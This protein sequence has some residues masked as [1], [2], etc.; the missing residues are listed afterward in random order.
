MD[1]PAEYVI[2]KFGGQSALARLIG[3][4]QSTVQHWAST[5]HIPAK[6]HRQILELAA[7]HGIDVR[8]EDLVVGSPAP[9]PSPVAQSLLPVAVWQG[10]LQ[11][12]NRSVPCCVLDDGRRIIS[13][14]GATSALTGLNNQ[15]SLETYLGVEALSDFMPSDLPERM[16]EFIIP[17]V[18]HKR[19][20]G[21]VAED[22]LEICT[23]Y[24]QA[25]E[26]QALQTDRQREIATNAA[27]FLA[28]CSKVGL[29]ALID[30]A[31]GYQ[32]QREEDALQV[33]LNL[34]L[35]DEMRPWEKT[36]PDD[37]WREFG[38]LTNWT[39]TIHKRPKYWGHLVNELVYDYLDR[40][41]A[42]WLRENQPQPRHGRNYHQW[43]S[44]QYGL[45]KL[46]EH[47]WMLIG[48]ASTCST[49][50]QLKG[51]MAERHGR[52]AVLFYTYVD[53]QKVSLVEAGDSEGA[54]QSLA[55]ATNS[56]LT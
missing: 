41:V 47:I 12:G 4:R 51:M 14:T 52:Q 56:N 53:S 8:P 13:R 16:I 17:E 39:G 50:G 31:T 40:D 48:M 3:K 29:I 20:M 10:D 5:G 38:R 27:L 32:Y 19:V 26:A 49:M 43:L 34:Y 1:N 33:K 6:W 35:A 21:L 18:T 15:G 7:E 45:R 23:A 9:Q 54:G 2:G 55:R 46:I 22:F 42:Q 36:F 25:L 24:V 30:E 44:D 28:A 11:L 37:L